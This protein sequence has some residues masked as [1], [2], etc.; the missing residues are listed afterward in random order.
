[1]SEHLFLSF[2]TQADKVPVPSNTGSDDEKHLAGTSAILRASQGH[3]F[4]DP[5]APTLREAAFWVYVR[6][7]LY[8]STINQQPPNIDFSLQLHPT[9]DS[10]H[11]SHPLAQLALETA[12]ANQM[13][14]NLAHVVNYCFDGSHQ[15]GERSSHKNDR[16]QELWD[17]V[18]KWA[19]DRPE[20][21]NPIW[22]GEAGD[23]GPFPEIWF[24]SDWHSTSSPD[25]N[26][27]IQQCTNSVAHSCIFWL[28]PLRLHHAPH[29]QARSQIRN[30]QRRQPVRQKRKSIYH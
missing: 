19:D 29:L 9:P 11:D 17:Q 18:Q 13:T 27:K 8:M 26:L 28:L 7:C 20:S 3:R 5:S 12:W 6:Q 10:M 15:H 25:V 24:T 21:F 1:V 14:W 16:W 30:P 4:L 22:Q 2:R 23:K